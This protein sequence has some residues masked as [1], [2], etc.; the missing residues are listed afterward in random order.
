MTSARPD[1]G[2]RP[3]IALV[4]C[5][6]QPRVNLDRD[7]P[8]LHRAL[9]DAGA[10]AD[11]VCWDDPDADW[12]AYDLALI[13][14]TWDYTWHTEAFLAWAERCAAL[15]T[16]ANPPEVVRWNSDK[17]YLG[18]LA[19]AGVPVVPTRYLAPGASGAADLL[20]SIMG[21]GATGIGAMDIGGIGIDG[22]A[23]AGGATEAAEAC[24]AAG[25]REYVIKP[26]QG[27]GGRFAA[28]YRLGDP[29]AAETARRHLAQM[30]EQGITAMVQPYLRRV[31]T[32]GERALLFFNGRLLHAIRKGAVLV[33]DTAY[34]ARKVSHPDPRPW[35]PT[36][37]E[38]A[39]ADLALKA[40][41]GSPE[42][43]YARV[44]LADGDNGQPLVM[45]L[46]LVEPNLF[47][48]LHP[49][50]L[51]TVV[52]AILARAKAVTPRQ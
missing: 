31:D 43:L 18:E 32:T 40:V 20:D 39:A 44:D 19:E 15:T 41:P 29:Q 11:A 28:R 33:P 2:A 17:R 21:I 12:A 49:D 52:D 38:L 51:P 27:A 45:E 37:A 10:D 34:D 5:R 35:Q 26:T 42:L 30:H 46:E 47:L 4:T 25:D 24:D 6:P 8:G 22:A 13:R 1:S 3:K 7:L 36:L 9:L 23:E 48:F 16:L 50:S 14:S